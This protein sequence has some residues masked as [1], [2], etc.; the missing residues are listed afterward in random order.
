LQPAYHFGADSIT[1]VPTIRPF[2]IQALSLQTRLDNE[3]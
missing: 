3:M 1:S 2:L